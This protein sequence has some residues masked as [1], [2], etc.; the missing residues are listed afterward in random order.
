MS[1]LANLA[2]INEQKCFIQ[3]L[4]IFTYDERKK[5]LSKEIMKNGM[6]E[7][8]DH[9]EIDF[10]IHNWLI[11]NWVVLRLGHEYNQLL[12]IKL[13]I[14]LRFIPHTNNNKFT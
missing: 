13:G 5:R 14:V 1:L 11:V 10:F 6:G 12:S 7:L 4:K 2:A 9:S 3:T 8:C